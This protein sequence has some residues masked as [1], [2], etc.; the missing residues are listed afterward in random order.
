MQFIVVIIIAVIIL[1]LIILFA[2]GTL[3]KLFGTT[4]VLG[5]A[6]TPEDITSYKLECENACY[7]AKQLSD[8]TTEWLWSSYCTKTFSNIDVNKDEEITNEEKNLH[9]WQYPLSVTCYKSITEP[10]GKSFDCHEGGADCECD[11][12]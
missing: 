8:S 1:T 4:T 12:K 2:T 7:Q 6:A 10:N 5:E 11:Q 9:C 3:G